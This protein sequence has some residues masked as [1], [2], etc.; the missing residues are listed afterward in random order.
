MSEFYLMQNLQSQYLSSEIDTI[1]YANASSGWL[2]FSKALAQNL[3]FYAARVRLVY[4]NGL[5]VVGDAKYSRGRYE[6]FGTDPLLF[7]GDKN[8]YYQYAMNQTFYNMYIIKIIRL[9]LID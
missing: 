7:Q 8:W 5:T 6:Y 3:D 2:S 1:E 9:L 4:K